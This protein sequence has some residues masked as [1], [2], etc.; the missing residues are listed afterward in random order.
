MNKLVS[1]G[2]KKF[3]ESRDRIKKEA[4]N[5]GFFDTVVVHTDE[6]ITKLSEYKNAILNDEF[7]TIFSC[8]R[9]GGYWMWKPLIVYEE[10][11]NMNDGD[12]LFY[13]DAGCSI[14]NK[15]ETINKMK[16]YINTVNKHKTGILAFRNPFEEKNWTKGDIF[17]HF[18]A[19]Y[20]TNQY[21]GR[22]ITANRMVIRKCE[23]SVNI[24]K[25]WWHTA[26]YHALLF[27]DAK[28][29]VLNSESFRQNRHDQSVFSIICKK[30]KV[31]E[32]FNW[33]KI[34]I[35]ATKIRK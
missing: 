10:L 1:Y 24:I 11:I 4:F 20:E 13:A 8:K 21:G 29:R 17:N 26:M 18:H 31:A 6:S 35:K 3:S 25:L 23:R 19:T 15:E 27:S 12:I 22:Q 5:I 16:E 14:P 32:D 30:Y 28:S 34:A 9:G 7:N 33:R 2:D